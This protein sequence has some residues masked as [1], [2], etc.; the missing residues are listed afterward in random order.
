MGVIFSR[1]RR[2]RETIKVMIDIYC[3]E[4]HGRA[5]SL[6]PDC[7]GLRDYALLRLAKCP[8]GEAKPT[9]A[10]CVVHCYQAAMREKVKAV[11]RYAG[12]KMMFKHPVLALFHVIDSYIYKPKRK[13]DRR[14]QGKPESHPSG[15]ATG[16]SLI[17]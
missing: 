1:F 2:E 15:R 9:C 3:R 5:G 13:A 12:P 11:M 6:C 14:R 16:P 7:A 10:K 4:K 17:L 8:F